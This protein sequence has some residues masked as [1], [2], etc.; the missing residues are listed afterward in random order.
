MYV[1]MYA[2]MYRMLGIEPRNSCLLDSYSTLEL[3]P[4]P[5]FP[6]VLVE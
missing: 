4:Q 6:K 3:H 2:C 5:S 1:Y